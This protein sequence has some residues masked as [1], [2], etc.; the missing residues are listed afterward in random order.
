MLQGFQFF[1]IILL[2]MVAGIVLF[3][4]YQVLGRRTGQ[5]RQPQDRFRLTESGRTDK[6][7]KDNVVP[8]PDRAAA[9][10]GAEAASS[11]P[12]VRGLMDIKL[13]DRGFDTDAFLEG[14]RGAYE[15]I[16]TAFAAGDRKALRPLLSEEVYE[17]FESAIAAR[18]VRG[19][20]TQFTFVAV[21]TAAITGA[22]LKAGVAEITVSFAGEFITA[23]YDTSGALV[24]GDPKAVRSVT[25]VWTFAREA[26]S[27]DPNWSLVATL[28]E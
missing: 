23:T 7:P 11:D 27:N 28:S 13:A 18:E 22:E 19:E 14:G 5:E 1:D 4:L 6:K 9:R 8:L 2:A 20:R 21:K 25:D 16:V 24:E 12:V 17:T 10:T 15:M 26:G 3:R